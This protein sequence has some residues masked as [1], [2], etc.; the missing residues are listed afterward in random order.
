VKHTS[1][2]E[3][4][5]PVIDSE[6]DDLFALPISA[7]VSQLSNLYDGY[8]EVARLDT[9][10]YQIALYVY[11]LIVIVLIAVLIISRLRRSAA[12]VSN[13]KEELQVTYASL[14]KRTAELETANVD[15]E[16]ATLEARE[17]SRL[18]DEFL[19]VMSH[20]LRT[21]LNAIIG[22]QG[23]LLMAGKLNERATHMVERA[24]ANAERLL[25]L[26]N[27]ILD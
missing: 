27:D 12:I 14:E 4:R 11:S 8:Y 24:Q 9:D 13:A 22:F 10:V 16:K 7:E 3:E 20:E 25:A 18:K 6:V 15:L 19:A 1:I 17:A 26:I 2:V 23:I 21:P 5:K